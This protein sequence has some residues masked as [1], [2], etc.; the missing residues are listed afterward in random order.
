MDRTGFLTVVWEETGPEVSCIGRWRLAV[1][2]LRGLMWGREG[3]PPRG[4]NNSAHK[5]AR[6]GRNPEFLLVG[7]DR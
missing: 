6:F 4:K 5:K 3:T 2:G 7:L 1:G